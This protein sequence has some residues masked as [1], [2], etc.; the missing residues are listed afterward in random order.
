MSKWTTNDRDT[1]VSNLKKY[2]TIGVGAAC[3]AT[4]GFGLVIIPNIESKVSA[5][6]VPAQVMVPKT[7]PTTS[8]SPMPQY[9]APAPQYTAPQTHSRTGAS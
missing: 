9:T 2:T 3:A 5:S 7:N 6:S 1:A 4:I 8:S